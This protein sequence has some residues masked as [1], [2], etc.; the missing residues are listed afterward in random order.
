MN[1]KGVKCLVQKKSHTFEKATFTKFLVISKLTELLISL[2]DP[3]KNSFFLQELIN[4]GIAFCEMVR[5]HTDASPY[6]CLPADQ[7]VTLTLTLGN[8]GYLL[9]EHIRDG[10]Y[11]SDP[12]GKNDNTK[13]SGVCPSS[14]AGGL[15][16]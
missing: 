15:K 13:R 1:K 9:R 12:D 16:K 11:R 2:S 7:Y 5:V 4:S 10:T 8:P 14:A 3:E 6:L